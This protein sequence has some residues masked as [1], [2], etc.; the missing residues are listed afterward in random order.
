MRLSE[1]H[2]DPPSSAKP[3]FSAITSSQGAALPVALGADTQPILL[4]M[5]F[6]WESLFL[7]A[8][9]DL[10]FMSFYKHEAESLHWL[11]TSWRPGR[12]MEDTP[13]PA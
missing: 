13:T 7:E 10:S 5:F 1:D 12:W 11:R 8:E 9:E 4:I 6:K 3:L 2:R